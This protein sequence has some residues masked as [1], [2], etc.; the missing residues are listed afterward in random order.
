MRW[1]LIIVI[2]EEYVI[3][4]DFFETSVAR[5]ALAGSIQ[6]KN[7]KRQVSKISA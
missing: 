6:V 1:D 4:G 5:R 2:N 3:S 7:N